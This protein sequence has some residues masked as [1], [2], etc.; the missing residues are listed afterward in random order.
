MVATPTARA[1]TFYWDGTS[2]VS[3]AG[4]GTAGGAW[5]QDNTTGFNWTTS[6]T[7]ILAGSSTQTTTNTDLFNF[8][9][10]TF[11]VAAGTITVSGSVAMGNT[12]FGSASGAITLNGGTINLAAASTITTNNTSNTIGSVVG[13]AGTSFTKAGTGTLILTAANTYTGAT[14]ITGGTLQVGNGTTGSLNGTAGTALTFTGTGTFNV[15]EAAGSTQGMGALSLN[16]GDATI[17]STAAGA[18]SIATLTFASLN[19]RTAGATANFSLATNT[20]STSVTPNRIVFTDTTNVP[21][22]SGSSNAGIFF[23]GNG[24]GRYDVGGFI[25]AVTYGTDTNANASLSGPAVTDL[26]SITASTDSQF[27]GAARATTTSGAVSGANTN[28]LAVTDGSLFA[29]GQILTGTNIAANSYITAIAGNTLTLTNPTGNA[30]GTA[31]SAGT[32]LTPYNSVTAQ[33]TG[34]LNTLNLSGVGASLTLGPGQT[35]SVNGILRTGGT[36]A[37]AGVISGGTGLQ[38]A[39]S[40]GDIVVRT[41]L[42]TDTL[43]I[44]SPILDNSGTRLTK[45]GAGTLLLNGAKTYSGGTTLSAGT[46]AIS[47]ATSFGTGSVSVTGSSKILANGGV[48]YANPISVG[49]PLILQIPSTTPGTATYSGQ[50]TG[51]SNITVEATLVNAVTGTHA[52]TATNNTFTGSVLMPIGSTGTG[53]GNDFFSFN[54]I[55]DA[56]TFTFRKRGH[57]NAIAYTGATPITFGTRQ[58]ALSADFGGLY[59]GGGANPVNSFRNNAADAA[60]TVTF[61]TN[62]TP[63]TIFQAGTFFFDGSNTGNNTFSG[64]IS[65]P[66]NFDLGIGKNGAGKWIL[67]GN[68]SYVGNVVIAGGTLSVGTIG[69]ANS[70]Q[71]LGRGAQIL[72]GNSGTS[73]VLEFT[74]S[75]STT[76]KQ[77]Q[78]GTTNNNHAGTGSILNNGTGSLTFSNTPFNVAIAGL[79]SVTRTLTLGGSYAGGNGANEIQGVIQNNTGTVATVPLVVSGSVWMLSATNTYTGGTIVNAPGTLVLSGNNTVSPTAGSLTI[80]NTTLQLQAN[81]GNTSAGISSAVG[82]ATGSSAGN[83]SPGLSVGTTGT[84]FQL[85]SDSAVTF[86]GTSGIAGLSG[87]TV[88]INVGNSGAGTNN[89]LTFSP[90]GNVFGGTNTF[91]ITGSNGYSLILGAFN[92]NNTGGTQTFNPTTA[93]VSIAGIGSNSATGTLQTIALSGTAPGN[94]MGAIVKNGTRDFAVTKAGVSTWTLTGTSTY[95]GDTSVNAGTLRVN[96]ALA[97]TSVFVNNAGRLEGTG[98]IAGPITVGEVTV[99]ASRGTIA[100]G[101]SVGPLNT[102]SETWNAGGSYIWEIGEVSGTPGTNW[103][104]LNITGTLTIGSGNTSSPETRFQI[105]LQTPAGTSP[106][107]ATGFNVATAYEWTIAQ[108]SAGVSGFIA[109]KFVLDTSGFN[110]LDGDFAVV[111]SG[112]NINI[113]Y[114]PVPEPGSIGVLALAG[115]G[116]LARRRRASR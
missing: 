13:G 29:V 49:A 1:A 50:L 64:V 24:Y 114:T 73:G 112:N 44:A 84:T 52:F 99:G 75:S 23:G 38:A 111:Q 116:L 68:N 27:V 17:T 15:A 89:A 98:T 46:V 58:I 94:T 105:K 69:D 100:P 33:T 28:T 71:P 109:D 39:V 97:T 90:N 42:S 67:S 54:S 22:A 66:S 51:S 106:G 76:N 2:P 79:T 78:L 86:A 40:G 30:I 53:S 101:N 74:G 3:N 4:F 77:V 87:K 80:N 103:D 8:G 26:G 104:L 82:Y 56:G 5:A 41:S 36:A 88:T 19:A 10:G 61:S 25:R 93:S 18:T 31:V 6:D 7:G 85:R 108:T 20:S 34:S 91:N 35:L 12:T 65:N 62:L 14:V 43:V 45:V 48:T 9:T 70:N 96:G 47:N 110:V 60:H 102:G 21:L 55:G 72:L 32:T 63:G 107:N 115:L 11:G 57:T 83:A 37:T 81:A 92:S 113:T 59:D 95:T 16:A